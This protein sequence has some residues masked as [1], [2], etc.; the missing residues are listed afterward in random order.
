ML[1]CAFW[2]GNFSFETQNFELDKAYAQTHLGVTPGSYVKLSV[3]DTGAGM[4]PE[5]KERM[6]EPFFTT[7]ELGKGTGLGLSTIYGIV[8]QS[9]GNI[10]VCSELNQG[11]TFEIYLPRIEKTLESGGRQ[12][13]SRNLPKGSETILV[14]EDE[15][16]VGKIVKK[17]LHELGYGVILAAQAQEAIQKASE[18][19]EQAIQL[20]ITD[21][22]MPGMSGRELKDHLISLRPKMKVIFMSGYT[23]DDIIRHGILKKEMHFIQKPFSMEA[24]AQKVRMVLDGTPN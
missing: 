12:I 17:T 7:K 23:D 10:W 22:V 11:T 19:D 16:G 14:V 18:Y 5:V 8:K 9:G 1:T 2:R 24:L 6:F 20:M 21:V 13:R 15:D 4:S 3:S